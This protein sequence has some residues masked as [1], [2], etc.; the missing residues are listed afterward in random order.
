MPLLLI[1][2]VLLGFVTR[3]VGWW[4]S[5]RGGQGFLMSDTKRRLVEEQLEDRG[6][7]EVCVQRMRMMGI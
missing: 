7:Q 1:Y 5:R 2:L 3:V 6:K 4:A